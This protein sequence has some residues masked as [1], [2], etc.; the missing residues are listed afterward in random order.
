MRI[1]RF[2]IGFALLLCISTSTYSQSVSI[3]L[4]VEWTKGND[5][6]HEDSTICY[7]ELVITY[8]NLS[9]TSYYF[10]RV[11]ESRYGLPMLPKGTLIQYP[12]GEFLNPDYFK[13]AITHGNY[14]N[15]HYDVII[16]GDAHFIKGWMVEND[17]LDRSI[18]QE[19]DLINDDL[20]DIY[21]YI[22]R[23]F[24]IRPETLDDNKT[25][26]TESDL[27]SDS[28]LQ[29]TSGKFVFLKSGEVYKESYNLIGFKLL[30]GSFTFV[31]Y[32]FIPSFVFTTP[33][34]DDKASKYR[35]TK[36]ELPKTV[37]DYTLYFGSFNTNK[38][39]ITF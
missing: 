9:D 22:Y 28:I 29:N 21:E 37:G 8:R 1:K 30:K 36:V 16:G 15:G 10:Q 31:V 11:S 19:T 3:E 32:P 4:S 14:S 33:V 24:I 6:F 34:W 2:F 18:E 39:S 35:N 7:P 26:Y 20:A 38:T 13:R 25:Q 12:I 17:S 27:L 5:P 23:K